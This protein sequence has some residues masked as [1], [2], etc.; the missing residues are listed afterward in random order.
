MAIV[1]GQESTNT[2]AENQ[3]RK[4]FEKKL[5]TGIAECNVVGINMSKEQMQALGWKV[6]K[7]PEYIDTAKDGTDTVT[8]SIILKETT[9]GTYLPLRFTIWDK[10]RGK[11][12]SETYQYL[13]NLG[14]EAWAKSEDELKS[15]FASRPYRL[16]K[17]GES[18]FYNF[19][20]K[21]LCLK[22]DDAE[23]EFNL[24]KLLRGNFRELHDVV[25]TFSEQKVVVLATINSYEKNSQPHQ[26]QNVCN[27]DFLPAEIFGNPTVNYFKPG[28]KAPKDIEWFTKNI[29]KEKFGCKDFYKLEPFQKY[30][31]SNNSVKTQ[32][33]SAAPK[34]DPP[35]ADDDLPF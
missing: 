22:G 34:A 31:P 6:E 15:T 29:T 4:K 24:N 9:T 21:W 13:N 26:V 2:P 16:A 8:I 27:L 1:K 3:E 33:V 20:R 23:L 11:S 14:W 5:Y 12:K 18:A 7:D 25:S 28:V 30:V 32:E 19:M 10:V 17:E 35:P